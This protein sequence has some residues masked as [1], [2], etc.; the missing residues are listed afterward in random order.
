MRHLINTYIQADSQETLGN[1]SS[2]SLTEAIIETGIHDVIAQRLNRQR[3]LSNNAIAEAIIN[4][5]RRTIVRD[6]HPQRTLSN[7]ARSSC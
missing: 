7:L 2:L 6:Q 5:V 3:N 1:L 4:N